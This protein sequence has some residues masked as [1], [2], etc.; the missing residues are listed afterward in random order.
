MYTLV[1]TCRLNDVDPRA[2]LAH[3]LRTLPDHPISRVDE[4]T[5]WAW[6]ASLEAQ[7]TAPAA[8]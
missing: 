6:K 4:L 5:P 1:E 8:A 7:Q 3:V 2:W